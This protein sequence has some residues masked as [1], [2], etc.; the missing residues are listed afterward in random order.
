MSTISKSVGNDIVAADIVGV[1][2]A[3]RAIR[4]IF[5]H[6]STKY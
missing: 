2:A 6:D 3:E 1:G 5:S 4:D